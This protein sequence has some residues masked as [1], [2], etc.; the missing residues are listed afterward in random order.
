MANTFIT[1]DLI[2]RLAYANLYE[3]A[4]MA[5]LVHR[6]YEGDFRGTQGATV[7][8]RKPAV[9]EAEEY[10]RGDGITVQNATETSIPVVLDTLLDVSFEVT[11]EQLTLEVADFNE[12]LLMPATE[13]LR[14]G[15]D[16]KILTLRDDI[17]QEVGVAPGETYDDPLVLVDAGRVLDQ[18]KVPSTQRYC[19]AGPITSAEWMKDPLFHQADQRGD[20]DGLREAS[21]GRKFG[22]DNFMSQNIEAAEANPDPGEPTTEVNVAFHRTAFALVT[23]TLALPAGAAKAAVFSGNGFGIRVVQDYDIDKKKDIVSLDILLGVKT[24]DAT[25]AVLVKG[26]DEGS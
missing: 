23:R 14:Q 13:A 2:A 26:E 11:A 12:Q 20:T 17:T 19:V 25:R 9:F 18:A 22:F 7:S 4:V 3:N 1:P 15:I 5:N 21:I 10:D 6:D 24:L 8:I 16:R